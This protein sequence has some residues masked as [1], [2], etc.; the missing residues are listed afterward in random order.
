MWSIEFPEL[1]PLTPTSGSTNSF[2]ES[3]TQMTMSVDQVL[4]VHDVP[5]RL[6]SRNRPIPPVTMFTTC[7]PILDHNWV[8][9][10]Q[11]GVLGESSVRSV[12]RSEHGW[13]V[14][15]CAVR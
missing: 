10:G 6:A 5:V 1:N 14:G 12:T 11:H 2:P 7:D 4:Q 3:C 8:K 15:N 9:R 13:W